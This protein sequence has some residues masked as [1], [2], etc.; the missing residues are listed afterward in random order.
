MKPYKLTLSG[1]LIEMFSVV[2]A[3]L[4]ALGVNEWRSS[5]SNEELGTA[6]Y[7]KIT[8]EIKN[9]HQKISRIIENHNNILADIDSVITRLRQ[10]RTDITFGQIIF[11]TPSSTA[12]EAAK[13]TTAVNYLDYNKVEKI[14]GVYSS[15]RIY[16]NV[17]D[18]VFQELVFLVPDKD[19]VKMIDQMRKQK[20]YLLNLIS[21]EKQL[22]EEYDNFLKT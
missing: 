19:P 16:S 18:R 17:S 7:Q 15:Q 14:T 11:E 10:N 21:I 1:I 12:W 6:A 13:L 22:I 3:V 5:R 4:L 8:N 9:N 20:V 2:F